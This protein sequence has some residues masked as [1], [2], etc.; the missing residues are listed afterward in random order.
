MALLTDA[1]KSRVRYHLGY[2]ASGFA[3]SLQFGLP[4]PVQ[5]VF[6]LEDAMSGLVESNALDRVR[7][8]VS[9]LDK[10]E[11]KMVCAVDQLV[12]E[13]LGEMTLRANHPDLLEKEYDRWSSRL[14]DIFGVPKY[15][16]SV[17][18]QRRGPGSHVTV[19]G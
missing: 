12:V 17:K 14:A 4:R 10:I 6:M 11:D 16:F 8:I 5:T 19:Q 9:I 18:T 1:E 15:P 7:K 3:A 13:K 2:L